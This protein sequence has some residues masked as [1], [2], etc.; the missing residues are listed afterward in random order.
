MKRLTVILAACVLV[1]AGT[2]IP[3]AAQVAVYVDY[4]GSYWSYGQAQIHVGSGGTYY[5]PTVGVGAMKAKISLEGGPLVMQDKPLYCVDLDHWAADYYGDRYAVP[6]DTPPEPPYN[7]WEAAWVYQKY[8][9]QQAYNRG[10]QLALWEIT[11]EHDWY[12]YYTTVHTGGVQW[13]EEH[14]DDGYSQFWITSYSVTDRN[15]AT[16]ILDDL[17]SS[18]ATLTWDRSCYYYRPNGRTETEGQGLI[19]DVPEPSSLFLLGGALI[20]AAGLAWR[21]R[22]SS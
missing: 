3:A 8:G 9:L 10:V 15:N 18:Y 12:T 6:P 14:A 4:Q 20:A 22:R 16:T 7:V 1:P 21:K 2:Y 17:Y 5:T 11:H 13:Y 19:G